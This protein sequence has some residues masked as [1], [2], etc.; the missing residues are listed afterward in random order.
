MRL[1]FRGP[2][3]PGV[4]PNEKQTC[5]PLAQIRTKIRRQYKIPVFEARYSAFQNMETGK[6]PSANLLRKK[7]SSVPVARKHKGC[8][9]TQQQRHTRTHTQKNNTKE[10]HKKYTKPETN[11]SRSKKRET[12]K[13]EKRTE[14]KTEKKRKEEET[15]DQRKKEQERKRKE[16]KERR[17]E[18]GRTE[19]HTP[20]A[21]KPHPSGRV[22]R[23]VVFFLESE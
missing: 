21:Q 16:K 19:T 2:E 5:P 17:K 23:N 10:Q 18:G 12:Q 15:K 20:R 22:P 11:L 3:T 8:N 6:W 7:K 14:R 4:R 9:A 1:R 13:T